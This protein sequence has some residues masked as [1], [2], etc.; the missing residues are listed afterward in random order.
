MAAPHSSFVAT[1]RGQN[2][3]RLLSCDRS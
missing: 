1:E 2:S 3:P